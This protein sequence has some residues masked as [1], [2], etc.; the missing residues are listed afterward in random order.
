MV[1]SM[2][3]ESVTVTQKQ[4]SGS[5][6]VIRRRS[7]SDSSGSK[8]TVPLGTQTVQSGLVDQSRRQSKPTGWQQPVIRSVSVNRHSEAKSSKLGT[9]VVRS[10]SADQPGSVVVGSA[11]CSG[12]SRAV[13]QSV[14]RRPPPSVHPGQAVVIKTLSRSLCSRTSVADWSVKTEAPSSDYE[15]TRSA[16]G[17]GGQQSSASEDGSRFIPVSRPVKTYVRVPVPR[18]EARGDQACPVSHKDSATTQ[19]VRSNQKSSH[20]QPINACHKASSRPTSIRQNAPQIIYTSPKMPLASNAGEK[21]LQSTIV[22]KKTPQSAKTSLST[23]TPQSTNI[24]QKMLQSIINDKKKHQSAKMPRSANVAQKMPRSTIVG[25]KTPPSTITSQSANVA[26][27]MPQS[28]IVGKKARRSTNAGQKVSHSQS[29]ITGQETTPQSAAS[30][31]KGTKSSFKTILAQVASPHTAVSKRRSAA[32]GQPNLER[33]ASYVSPRNP[34]VRTSPQR[35]TSSSSSSSSSS[36][37]SPPKKL[38]LAKK[39][40]V[41]REP[42]DAPRQHAPAPLG[43]KRKRKSSGDGQPPPYPKAKKRPANFLDAEDIGNKRVVYVTLD[44]VKQRMEVPAGRVYEAERQRRLDTAVRCG[45]TPVQVRLDD[46]EI[47]LVS[48]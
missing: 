43:G 35:H 45:R 40:L 39:F 42:A 10:Y 41:K 33:R 13:V 46:E 30:Q 9:T 5:A 19:L 20:S 38:R 4:R 25:K 48:I 44:E 28:T 6:I 8:D 1:Q 31:S 14:S 27:K 11:G 15:A 18:H 21:T 37:P 23:K 22:G 36:S 29:A 24:S 2:S 3:K 16:Q 34:S 26:Q 32:P 17:R 12:G 7:S 47:S